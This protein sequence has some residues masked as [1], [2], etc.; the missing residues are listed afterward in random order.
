M[1]ISKRGPSPA[2]HIKVG[3]NWSPFWRHI[4]LHV[5]LFQFHTFTD[6]HSVI[7]ASDNGAGCRTAN[8]WTS[9]PELVHWRVIVYM[10]VNGPQ[11]G[12]V[13]QTYTYC[14]RCIVNAQYGFGLVWK[15]CTSNKNVIFIVLETNEF[16]AV[17]TDTF[18]RLLIS[19]FCTQ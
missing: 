9:K 12:I 5:F 13:N 19:P 16:V 7:I 3:A 18:Y 17:Y 6:V 4:F 14:R 11:C 10:Y 2:V 1:Q 8:Q 15:L